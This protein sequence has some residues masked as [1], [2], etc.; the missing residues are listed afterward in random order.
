M[1]RG[2]R[3]VIEKTIKDPVVTRLKGMKI[4]DMKSKRAAVEK[5]LH[6]S[7]S[8][9]VVRAKEL[10]SQDKLEKDRLKGMGLFT[11]EEAYEELRKGGVPLSF[12]A[13]G[14]RVE[15]R[16]VHSEKI[17]SKRLIPKP[18]IQD[19]VALSNEYYSVKQAF[20]ELKKYEKLNLRAF[21]GRI[22]KNS[23]PS[24]KIGT[25]RWV[26]KSA[27]EGLSHI[28]KNYYDVGDA[29]TEMSSRGIK[30]KRNAFERRLDRNRVPHEKIGG[31]RVI[32]KEVLEELIS[33]ELALSRMPKMQ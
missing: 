13:F 28:C 14:G 2:K 5:E 19:W 16:S 21:I 20:N 9:I 18:V 33:K 27:I 1:P 17:G 12:R 30:I 15:R 3:I 8:G 23:I 7:I 22:E 10:Y 26:P 31:R 29:V 32:A 11:L 25:Q 6:E 4:T 24:L